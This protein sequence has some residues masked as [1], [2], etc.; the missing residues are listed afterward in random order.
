[1]VEALCT[2][3]VVYR[4]TVQGF[5]E[6]RKFQDSTTLLEHVHR[7]KRHD[8]KRRV[9][10]VQIGIRQLERRKLVGVLGI[11]LEQFLILSFT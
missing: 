7:A 1:M 3:L 2:L 8:R 4:H 11:V 5:K 10:D 9:D 6:A